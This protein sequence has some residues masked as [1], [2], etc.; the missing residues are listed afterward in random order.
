MREP[1]DTPSDRYDGFGHED[2]GPTF[3]VNWASLGLPG[4]LTSVDGASP[5]YS[6]SHQLVTDAPVSNPQGAVATNAARYATVWRH[7]CCS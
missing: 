5:P 3:F 6:G 4:L 1:R 7:L 2:D